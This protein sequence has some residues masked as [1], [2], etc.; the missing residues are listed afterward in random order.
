MQFYIKVVFKK[1]ETQCFIWVYFQNEK[2][3]WYI[4][5]DLNKKKNSLLYWV[6]IYE[7]KWMYFTL[8]K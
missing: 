2:M 7:K 5:E 8:I 3:P 4:Y 1:M 6:V